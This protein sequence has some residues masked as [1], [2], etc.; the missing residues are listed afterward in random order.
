MS[1]VTISTTLWVDPSPVGVYNRSVGTPI[2]RSAARCQCA[3]AA[4]ARYSGPRA[5][6]SSGVRLRVVL[7]CE[8]GD[9]GGIVGR[10]AGRGDGRGLLDDPDRLVEQRRHR[11]GR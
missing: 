5:T 9:V 6:R 8:L 3:R 7:T 1:S 4:L 10:S 11:S 2:S